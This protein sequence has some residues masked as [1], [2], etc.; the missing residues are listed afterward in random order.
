[1]TKLSKYGLS[2]LKRLEW[3]EDNHGA[4]LSLF[5]AEGLGGKRFLQEGSA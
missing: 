3:T 2:V 5:F 4:Q 1:M